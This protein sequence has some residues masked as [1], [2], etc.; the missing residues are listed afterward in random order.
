MTFKCFTIYVSKINGFIHKY[1]KEKNENVTFNLKYCLNILGGNEI[2]I[3]VL[4]LVHAYGFFSFY[5]KSV[6]PP[7]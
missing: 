6:Q 4:S 2:N 7:R 1:I 5:L 3:F